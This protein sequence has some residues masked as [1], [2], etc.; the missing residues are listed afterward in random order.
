MCA[1]AQTFSGVFSA[2]TLWSTAPVTA[3]GSR[4][5]GVGQEA[6]Q[7]VRQA[8][9]ADA[10]VEVTSA[11]G[12][13][14]EVDELIALIVA[15]LRS[16]FVSARVELLLFDESSQRLTTEL[17]SG[18][19]GVSVAPDE[20][21]GFLGAVL[22]GG[23]VSRVDDFAE[24]DLRAEWDDAF[25][26]SVSA[27]AAPLKN[28]LGRG[29]GVLL[30]TRE[31]P[32]GF[33]EEDTRTLAV[34][35]KQA[36]MA[37]DNSRLLASLIRKNRE[38]ADA[39]E[40]LT[41]RLRDLELLFELER[42]TAHAA[43]HEDLARA[44]LAR[45]AR[46]CAAGGA[47]LVLAEEGESEFLDYSLTRAEPVTGQLSEAEP[48]FQVSES[49]ARRAFLAPV[50]ELGLPVQID[51][52][53]ASSPVTGPATLRSLI[54]EPLE[55]DEGKVIGA[56]A[57][58]NKR[59]GP[60]TPEDLGLLRLV[61]A[62]LSTALQ[63]FNAKHLRQREERLSSIGRLLSQV[64]HDLKSPLTVISGYVQLM[65]ESADHETRSK[66]ASEILKQFQAMGAMQREVLAFARGETEIFVRRVIVDRLLSDLSEQMQRDLDEH[67]VQLVIVKE[68]K[69]VAYVDSERLTRALMNLVVNA[70]E[71]MAVQGGGI[72]SINAEA[73]GD[74]L[75]IR[76]ADTGPG[77]PAKIAPRL[78]Q[79][80][81]TLGKSDGTGLGLAIVKRIVEEHGGT[82]RLCPS[83][84]GACFVLTFPGAIHQPG[85]DEP[86]PLRRSASAGATRS[87]KKASSRKKTATKV[88]QKQASAAQTKGVSKSK[89]NARSPQSKTKARSS[90]ARVKR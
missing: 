41:R 31:A 37:I 69:L 36:A 53:E 42:N 26:L 84:E 19:A 52:L 20:E 67:H 63:L 76:V 18:S 7:L 8:R 77:V 87:S 6:H 13:F 86:S 14:L 60:F 75:K 29:M 79:S 71:A 80:F 17:A 38:L 47:L 28:N 55:G 54:A 81:V 88:P 72:I 1:G 44:A 78:F 61:S 30:A 45:L 16:L 68:K 64:V 56:L 43:S 74:T 48:Q 62:N 85:G 40:Q 82:V 32:A 15:K 23:S 25:G 51:E 4:K 35:A 12:D 83:K 59:S 10:L 3:E 46:A 66:Y 9:L 21:E 50:F 90:Q 89:V 11:F 24:C 22:R 5:G 39:Q 70:K 34:F 73:E 2:C 57:L 65:E 27:V 33:D 49:H 58:V